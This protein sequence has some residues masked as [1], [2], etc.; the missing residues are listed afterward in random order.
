MDLTQMIK[1]HGSIS[2]NETGHFTGFVTQ[3]NVPADL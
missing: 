1:P 2:D 3:K